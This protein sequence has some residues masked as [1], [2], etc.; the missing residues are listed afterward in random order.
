MAPRVTIDG[1]DARHVSTQRFKRGAYVHVC[2]RYRSADGRLVEVEATR[3]E[4]HDELRETQ[5][6][7]GGL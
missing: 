3:G 4:V 7:V 1:K 2:H 5:R 6:W